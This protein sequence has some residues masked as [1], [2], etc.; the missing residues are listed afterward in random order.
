[1]YAFHELV[2]YCFVGL[3]FQCS[4]RFKIIAVIAGCFSFAPAQCH[5]F[6][7]S[8]LKAVHQR[9]DSIPLFYSIFVQ[10]VIG[11]DKPEVL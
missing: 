8:Q 9:E 11:S 10:D 7:E 6:G 2:L 3:F 1:M 4:A 5:H